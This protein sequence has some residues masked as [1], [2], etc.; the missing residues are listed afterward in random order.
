[1]KA[2]ANVDRGVGRATTF[3]ERPAERKRVISE[4]KRR[5]EE[6]IPYQSIF[7]GLSE[8]FVML[9]RQVTVHRPEAETGVMSAETRPREGR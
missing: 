6:N 7:T 8:A 9:R 4:K 3:K 2:K 1:M 5:W